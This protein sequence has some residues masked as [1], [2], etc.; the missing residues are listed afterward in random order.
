LWTLRRIWRFFLARALAR[1]L[2]LAPAVVRCAAAAD[3]V[4]RTLVLSDG[5]DTNANDP[6]STTIASIEPSFRNIAASP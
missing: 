4:A 2:A 5:V 1:A 6:E 3:E